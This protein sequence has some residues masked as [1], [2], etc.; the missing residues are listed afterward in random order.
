ML[1]ER[2]ES[3]RLALP[4]TVLISADR[5]YRVR[6]DREEAVEKETNGP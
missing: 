3:G 2:D 6:G 1:R 5:S 4:E